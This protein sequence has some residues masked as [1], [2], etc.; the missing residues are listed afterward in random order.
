[1]PLINQPYVITSSNTT[2]TGVQIERPCSKLRIL[3][4]QTVADTGYSK[5]E[6]LITVKVQNVGGS[7]RPII[8]TLPVAPLF[9]LAAFHEGHFRLVAGS[10]DD[11][12]NFS[13]VDAVIDLSFLGAVAL[14]PGQ[15]IEVVLSNLVAGMTYELYDDQDAVG[16]VLVEPATYNNFNVKKEST[17]QVINLVGVDVVAIR[18]TSG[19]NGSGDPIFNNVKLTYMTGYTCTHEHSE[20]QAKMRDW[21]DLVCVTALGAVYGS[22]DFYILEVTNA[23][24]MEINKTNA[25]GVDVFLV[26]YPN[27]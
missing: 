15:H 4:K 25:Y 2:I 11:V 12:F 7:D 5:L 3:A 10:G 21:N 13:Y 14:V 18:K 16:G 17:N 8:T 26:S 22:L 6:E 20:L 27:R 9:E 24:Q 1:M 19:R 23:L